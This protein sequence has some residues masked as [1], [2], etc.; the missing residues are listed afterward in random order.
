MCMTLI[1][2]LFCSVGRAQL[3]LDYQSFEI[4]SDL[5]TVI[6]CAYGT[7]I[8]IKKNSF[9]HNGQ[10][11]EN[12]LVLLSVKE[13]FSKE[14]MMLE[15]LSTVQGDTVLLSNGMLEIVA[16]LKEDSLPLQLNKNPLGIRIPAVTGSTNLSLYALGDSSERGWELSGQGLILDT[17]ETYQ[18]RIIWEYKESTKEEYK[19]W[20]AEIAAN[21]ANQRYRDE[22]VFGGKAVSIFPRRRPK[23]YMIP[24]AIDTIWACDQRMPSFY[25][26]DIE[27]LG[28]YNIDKRRRMPHPIKIKVLTKEDSLMVF[29]ILAEELIAAEGNYKKGA[30]H[31]PKLPRGKRAYII[32]YR[33][34]NEEFL[35]AVIQDIYL[36]Y[37]E[38]ELLPLSRVQK[39]V[40]RKM[41]RDLN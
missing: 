28:W 37:A 29:L 22:I 14:G 40:F 21:Q 27:N 3:S 18:Q 9:I 17:C 4:Q 19:Q 41:L 24:V 31:F 30:Y 35:V 2:M 36:G 8:S 39:G 13:V 25:E 12:R 10:M 38:I 15:G 5:D 7:E 26:F 11:I 16:F 20:E 32:A 23:S 34:E 1:P 6:Y 33:V